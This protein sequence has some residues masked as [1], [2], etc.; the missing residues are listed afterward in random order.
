MS[1][2]TPPTSPTQPPAPLAGGTATA[3][4]RF[5]PSPLCGQGQSNADP[6]EVA[7]GCKEGRP[8]SPASLGGDDNARRTSVQG[9]HRDDTPSLPSD[10][11]A[12]ASVAPATGEREAELRVKLAETQTALREAE[13][14]R[15]EAEKLLKRAYNSLGLWM[16]IRDWLAARAQEAKT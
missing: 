12:R 2:L 4:V 8:V 10:P 16:D 9:L 11:A 5:P 7:A 6:A 14:A 1:N 3:T 15:R 13:A